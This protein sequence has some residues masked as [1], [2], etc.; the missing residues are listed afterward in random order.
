MKA[1]DFTGRVFGRLTALKRES[2]TG[3]RT[4]YV[5]SCECGAEITV[6]GSSLSTGNTKSCGCLHRDLLKTRN[7]GHGLTNAAEY[8][9]WVDMW[10]RTTVPTNKA[11][12]DYKDRAPPA[13]WRDFQV[14]YAELGPRPSPKHSLDRIEND[15][16]YGPGNCRW[17]TRVEQNN[18]TRKNVQ[19]T[20]NGRTQTAA[21]W[22]KELG[23]PP[24]R[25]YDRLA[26][27]WSSERIL[28]EPSRQREGEPA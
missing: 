24:K 21:L 2:E 28:N 20:F 9:V 12:P 16:P 18:N 27:G 11:Y 13:V 15:Q 19:I 1:Q 25:L 17:A 5:C 4:R 7:T 8:A 6:D 23:V 10:Q 14:F 3:K 26:A 22:A